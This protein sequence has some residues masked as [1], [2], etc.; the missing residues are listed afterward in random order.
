[1]KEK[2]KKLPTKTAKEDSQKK[3]TNPLHT[4]I[5]GATSKNGTNNPD[6][7]IN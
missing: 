1:M 5:E 6:L 3:E 4:K 7:N 2:N